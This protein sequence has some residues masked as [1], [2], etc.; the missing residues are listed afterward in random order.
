M[1]FSLFLFGSSGFVCVFGCACMHFARQS[2]FAILA[3]MFLVRRYR[4]ACQPCIGKHSSMI[5]GYMNKEC[6]PSVCAPS[7]SLLLSLSLSLVLFPQFN[8]PIFSLSSNVCMHAPL[9]IP[10]AGPLCAYVYPKLEQK[11]PCRVQK[12]KKRIERNTGQILDVF[13]IGWCVFACITCSPE[14]Y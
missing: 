1:V 9:C 5:N 8:V 4:Y 7:L 13:H 2:S 6:E 11:E 14:V 10:A 12:K 3:V